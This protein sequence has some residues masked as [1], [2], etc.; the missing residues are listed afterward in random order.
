M[1]EKKLL[2][3]VRGGRGLRGFRLAGRA[4]V[5]MLPAHLRPA[6]IAPCLHNHLRPAR[7]LQLKRDLCVYLPS[8][9]EEQRR[10]HA[11]DIYL[12]PFLIS[13]SH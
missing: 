1:P 5:L 10:L 12:E 2:R 11:P 7:R 13:I 9:G 3:G 8:T 6:A 4:R